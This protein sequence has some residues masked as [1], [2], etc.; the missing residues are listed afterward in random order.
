MF[1]IARNHIKAHE[2]LTINYG[3]EYWNERANLNMVKKLE[4]MYKTEDIEESE[5][6]PGVVDMEAGKVRSEF[7]VP[8]SKANPVMSGIAIQS[9]GQ[10]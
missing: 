5:I 4:T 7:S 1:F 6:Q 10:S 9:L 8:N 3:T 2:E